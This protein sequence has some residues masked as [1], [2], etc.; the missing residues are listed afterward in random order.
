MLRDDFGFGSVSV[1]GDLV[2]DR[3]LCIWSSVTLVVDRVPYGVHLSEAYLAIYDDCKDT[4]I[5]DLRELARLN[6]SQRAEFE[7]AAVQV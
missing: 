1:I 7:S 2:H 6:P 3:P 4:C 5:H